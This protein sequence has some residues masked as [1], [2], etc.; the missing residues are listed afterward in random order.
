MLGLVVVI[1]VDDLLPLDSFSWPDGYE[2]YLNRGDK[3]SGVAAW[4]R[5]GEV[6]IESKIDCSRSVSELESGC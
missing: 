2:A 5:H 1:C 6:E 4:S 3:V